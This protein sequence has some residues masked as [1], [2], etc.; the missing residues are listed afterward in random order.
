MVCPLAP[1]LALVTGN[2]VAWELIVAQAYIDIGMPGDYGG[3]FTL[4]QLVGPAKSKE[5]AFTNSR[6]YGE[7]GE[8]LGLFNRCVADEELMDATM[9]LARTIAN[10]PAQTMR[11]LKDNMNFGASGVEV[12]PCLSVYLW[13]PRSALPPDLTSCL[14]ILPPHAESHLDAL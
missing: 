14:V 10:K 1:A 11:R 9:E 6:V 8:K 5:L 4:T 7:E 3:T 2:C 13:V 12:R